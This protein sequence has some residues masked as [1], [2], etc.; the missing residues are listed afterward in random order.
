MEQM[1]RVDLDAVEALVAVDAEG[2]FAKAASSLHKS[3]SAVSH[4]I[5]RLEAALG[6][7][8]F[9]RSGHRA[10]LTPAGRA[11]VDEGQLLLARAR[12]LE[13]LAARFTAGWEPRL[14]VVVDGV[15]P[16]RPVLAALK[17]LGDEGVP[18]HVHVVTEFLTGVR[19]RFERDDADLM[20]VWDHAPAAH[21]EAFALPPIELV[22][23]AHPDHPVATSA[24]HDG[25]SLRHHREISVHDSAED[26]AGIDT[27][28]VGGAP[29]FYVP[30]FRAKHEALRMGLGYGWLP[31]GLAADDLADGTLVEIAVGTGSRRPFQPWLVH[32]IDRPLGRT[33]RRLL[34]LL[35]AGWG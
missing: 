19:R 2:G 8:L 5:Q 18:T 7:A 30:D 28:T 33:G 35:R 34:E 1:M 23:V 24:P 12:R 25:T 6:V 20:I 17:A 32:R 16:S 15:L 22:L 13:D 31:V 26:T 27:N 10:V 4:A 3:Q 11:I 9:D 14:V 21:L 29:V